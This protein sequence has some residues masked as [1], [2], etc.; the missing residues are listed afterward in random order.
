L[1][2]TFT[3]DIPGPAGGA[4]VLVLLQLARNIHS[5]NTKNILFISDGFD[6][7]K[8][9]TMPKNYFHVLSS[10]ILI[11]HPTGEWHIFFNYN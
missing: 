1:A 3:F 10:N 9:T 8:T 2:D 7:A 11:N 5:G 6:T 4:A